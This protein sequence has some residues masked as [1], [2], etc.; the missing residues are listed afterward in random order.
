[1]S[2]ILAFILEYEM[3]FHTPHIIL[4]RNKKRVH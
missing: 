2:K 1:M 4:N 3:M